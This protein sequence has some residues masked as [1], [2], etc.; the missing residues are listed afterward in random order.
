[1][2]MNTGTIVMVLDGAK[3][4]LLRNAGSRINPD[5]KVVSQEEKQVLASREVASDSPGKTHSS[6]GQRRS[7]FEETDWH[8]QAE[9]SFVRHGTEVVEAALFA[10]PGSALVVIAPARALGE[11]RK[12][13]GPETKSRLITEID[14][15]LT[16]QTSRDILAVVASYGA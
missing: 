4:L 6:L 15:D 14:K 9:D 11:L 10:V 3:L 7:S 1:M 5:L 8:S 12:H 16:G 13:Y 2:L